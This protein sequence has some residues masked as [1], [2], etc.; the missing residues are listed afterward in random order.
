MP[1]FIVL[2]SVQISRETSL[3]LKLLKTTHYFF[4]RKPVKN[5]LRLEGSDRSYKGR[6]GT[7]CA[8]HFPKFANFETLFMTWSKIGYPIYDRCSWQ[9]CPKCK[10]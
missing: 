9:S 10:L 4:S 7:G 5:S 1:F 8:A 2:L 3:K 6:E